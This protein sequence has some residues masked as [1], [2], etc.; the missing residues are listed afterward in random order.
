MSPVPAPRPPADGRLILLMPLGVGHL[1]RYLA[2][3]KA[4]GPG[5][6]CIPAPPEVLEDVVAATQTTE[7]TSREVRRHLARS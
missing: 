3:P 2:L 7:Q 5:Y 1:G 4:D 6:T